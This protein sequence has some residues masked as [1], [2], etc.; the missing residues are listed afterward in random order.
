MVFEREWGEGIT[1]G[2]F[3]LEISARLSTIAF[4]PGQGR[5]LAYPA[6]RG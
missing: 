5:D 2:Q 1:Y 3:S 4:V 6:G